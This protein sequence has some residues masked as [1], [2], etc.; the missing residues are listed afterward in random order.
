MKVKCHGTFGISIDAVRC[1]LQRSLL[2]LMRTSLRASFLSAGTSR[3]GILLGYIIRLRWG[4]CARRT[5][6][7][8]DLGIPCN[9]KLNANFGE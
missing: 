4:K 7:L 6:R 9:R 3:P 5:L 2:S 8:F 1:A